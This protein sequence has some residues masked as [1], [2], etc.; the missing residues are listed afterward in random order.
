MSQA[1]TVYSLCGMCGARCPAEITVD[2]TGRPRWISGNAHSA[3]G[4]ALCPRGAASLAQLDDDKRVL[5]PFIR[6]GARGGGQWREVS[7]DEALEHVAEQWQEL[8]AEH[9]PHSLLWSERPGPHSDFSKAFLRG[10]GSPNYCTHNIT[11]QHNVHEA[12]HSLTGRGSQQ[13]A[14][15]YA[16]CNMLVLQGRNLFEALSTGEVNQVLN[17]LN[18][19]ENPCQLTVMDVR[20]TV[21]AAKAQR[22]WLLRPGTDYALNLAVI[23][24]LL[25]DGLCKSENLEKIQNLDKLQDFVQ[26]YTPAWAE[27][28][29]QVSVGEIEALAR[30]LAEAAPAVIWHPGWMASRYS[31]S[32]A[33]S[34]S[35]Y[36]INALL[37]S[38]GAAGG[39]LPATPPDRD[40]ALAP[41][42]KLYPPVQQ[43][44]ADG[45]GWKYPQL[46]PQATLL[47]TA[48]DAASDGE[49]YALSSYVALRHD[50]LVALPD[51]EAVKLKL[52]RIPFLLCMTPLWSE[53]AWHSDVVLPLALNMESDF[54]LLTKPGLKPTAYQSRRALEPQGLSRPDWWVLSQLARRMGLD[55]LA[56]D[57]VEDIWAAQL[58]GTSLTVEDFAAKGFVPLAEP[59]APGNSSPLL[60]ASGLAEILC[61]RWE[62]AGLPSLQPYVSPAPPPVCE[63]DGGLSFRLVVGRN[64]LHTHANTQNLPPLREHCAENQAWIHPD[65]A[66]QLHIADGE[67]AMLDSHRP[68]YIRVK[69]T[70]DIHPEALFM[71][72]GFGHRLPMESLAY[73]R[74]AADQDLMAGGLDKCDATGLVPALQEHFVVLRKI[75]R[76]SA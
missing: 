16:H 59:A 20:A 17:A 64:A 48:F 18:R 46:S 40:K 8:F 70:P 66:A 42:E 9:G 41:L 36:M 2:S 23:H 5:S 22:F 73:G 30:Q 76:E 51:A 6:Q 1:R 67:L 27:Q 54:P 25:R 43:Q 10:L 28:E 13:W 50:P 7:W 24:V 71:M 39:L 52:S 74:G 68:L 53:M 62:A 44:R 31:Q 14:Y 26:S 63:D 69:V 37:G 3:S 61:P 4:T 33:L 58:Q 38:L 75:F 49:P 65:K 15:D 57:S 47:H 21:T 72:H 12:S 29:C 60:T 34:R 11:C 56:F 19:S 55:K 45:V 32:L 35:A